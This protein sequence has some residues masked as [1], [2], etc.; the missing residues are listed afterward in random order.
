[1]HTL[2]RQAVAV[3]L[4]GGRGTRL[5]ALTRT[6]C[7]PALYIGGRY[8]SIDFTLS[9]CVNSGVRRIGVATQYRSGSLIRHIQRSWGFLHRELGE[10]IE[11]LPAEHRPDAHGYSGTAD[12]VYQ[13]LAKLDQYRPRYVLVLAA[14][15]VY[16]MHYGDLLEFHRE[17]GADLTVACQPVPVR[18]ARHFGILSV[19]G[20]TVTAFE[21]KPRVAPAGPSPLASMGI[22]VFDADLLREL[23]VADAARAGSQHDFGRDV[24]PG[25]VRA[26]DIR[27]CAH[28][29]RDPCTGGPGYWRD[30]G[31]VDAYWQ[32]NMELLVPG[33][34]LDLHDP[35]WPIWSAPDRSPPTR[36][37][38]E[39]GGSPARVAGSI[40]GNS[41]QVTGAAVRGSVLCDGV[42]V[43]PGSLIED[44]IL[45]PGAVVGKGCRVRRAVVEE[46]LS[47]PDGTRLGDS[48]AP[49]AGLYEVSSGGVTVLYGFDEAAGREAPVPAVTH[50]QHARP[51]E[52][53]ALRA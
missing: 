25:C 50:W 21:E 27:V 7:K 38:P 3:V 26:A 34:G 15:H 47:L 49:E 16:R 14:D 8:R 46:G 24:I 30:I 51:D 36:I 29:L 17:S 20:D 28:R 5:G 48:A 23:L 39:I 40:V 37:L 13:N 45:L 2:G 10:F 43:G 44:S 1:M 12:A 31:T 35:R 33:G 11:I 41:C 22:Y 52:V 19:D 18:Q 32:A 42:Q 53:T 4:A 9:N 6:R